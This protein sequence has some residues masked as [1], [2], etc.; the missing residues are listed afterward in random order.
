MSSNYSELS[1][2]ITKNISK[3]EK[4][5]TGIYFTPPTIIQK[6]IEFLKPFIKNYKSILEP[7]CGSCEYINQLNKNNSN[8]QITGIE[9]NKTIYD[10]IKIYE[11]DNVKLIN[12]NFITHSFDS[13]YDLIISSLLCYEE[14]G[15]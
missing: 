10:K 8:I 6:N 13:K 7:S 1:R 4:K 14:K 2:D 15:S 5:D 12:D 3:K 11:K 9:I